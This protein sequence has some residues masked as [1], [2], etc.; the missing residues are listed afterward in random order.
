[1]KT[2]RRATGLL[3]VLAMLLSAA[4]GAASFSDVKQQA[5]YAQAT[6]LLSELGLLTGYEDGTFHPEATI[7]RAEACAVVYRMLTGSTQATAFQGIAWFK[8]VAANNWAGGYIGYCTEQGIVTG[9]PDGSFQPDATITIAEMVTMVVRALGLDRDESGKALLMTYP[10]SY[11]LAAQEQGVLGDLDLT[12][13]DPADRGTVALLIYHAI[14]DAQ[15]RRGGTVAGQGYRT[16]AES[17]YHLEAFDAYVAAYAGYN[18]LADDDLSTAAGE[19]LLYLP[20]S[21]TYLR[22]DFALD[23]PR[24]LL[25]RSV[26]V[27]RNSQTGELAAVIRSSE[28]AALTLNADAFSYDATNNRITVGNQT[29]SLDLKDYTV[30]YDS[31]LASALS[32]RRLLS[33]AGTKTA[34]AFTFLSNDTDSGTFDALIVTLYSLGEID[35]T[36]SDEVEG[37]VVLTQ[38]GLAISGITAGGTALDKHSFQISLAEATLT[39][40]SI[41]TGDHVMMWYDPAGEIWQMRR[42]GQVTGTYSSKN[43]EEGTYTIN[44]SPYT[45][46]SKDDAFAYDGQTLVPLSLGDQVQAWKLPGFGYLFDAA[47]YQPMPEGE[48][49]YLITA[50]GSETTDRYGTQTTYYLTAWNSAGKEVELVVLADAVVTGRPD[51]QTEPVNTSFLSATQADSGSARKLTETYVSAL[52]A[53]E[54]LQ[55]GR[56]LFV[57]RL[58]V[59]AGGKVIAITAVD[60]AFSAER[61]FA[62]ETGS[63]A[64]K[65]SEASGL[66]T[67]SNSSKNLITEQTV[68]FFW[69]DEKQ[70]AT[71]YAGAFPAEARNSCIVK[72]YDDDQAFDPLIAA[73]FWGEPSSLEKA[74]LHIGLILDWELVP[75]EENSNLVCLQYVIA[76]DGAIATYRTG[77]GEAKLL[78]QLASAFPRVQETSYAADYAEQPMVFETDVEGRILLKPDETVTLDNYLQ[79]FQPAAEY[80]NQTDEKNQLWGAVTAVATTGDAAVISLQVTG[81][82]GVQT[83]YR[84]PVA[85]DAAVFLVI[86]EQQS[87]TIAWQDVTLGSITQVKAGS[88]QYART[89]FVLLS[90][91]PDDPEVSITTIF[92]FQVKNA[93][94]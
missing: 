17:A 40:D 53:I 81:P 87:E 67:F 37:R 94:F 11:L 26:K 69:D 10:V 84:L 63:A 59:N 18:F 80:D 79:T 83:A 86:G 46:L 8:D 4:A 78:D 93:F 21:G 33:L 74:G 31:E 77:P 44:A 76:C 38:Q 42:I 28:N 50:M 30:N 89:A 72:Y 65:Y 16:L 45:F 14:F 66:L 68:S 60:T 73:L 22:A 12:A 82:G 56:Q 47:S 25:Y 23:S 62:G 35:Y 34:A 13:Q 54:G 15:Y 19:L 91:D 41:K 58:V 92:F 39:G 43:E 57:A 51:G 55:S 90:T 32:L 2:L 71:V 29:Y 3:L 52:Q 27:F 61:Q 36:G 6:E 7:T 75:S 9:Y 85:E 48:E 88:S 1:M 20:E 64:K 24:D 49:L 5:D 70:Q